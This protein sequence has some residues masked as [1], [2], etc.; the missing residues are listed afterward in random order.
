MQKA[1][2]K[3]FCKHCGVEIVC[4]PW[5][6]DWMH[7]SDDG[8]AYYQYCHCECDACKEDTKLGIHDPCPENCC[9]GEEADL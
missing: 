5:L 4:W 7:A 3:H 2:R 8:S 6:G 9:D 1:V